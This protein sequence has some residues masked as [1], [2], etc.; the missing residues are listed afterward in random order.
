[1]EKLRAMGHVIVGQRAAHPDR[2][3]LLIRYEAE[4]PE[5]TAAYH[6]SRRAVLRTVAEVVADGVR[7]GRFRPVDPSVAA[8]GVLGMCN[9]VAWWFRPGGTQGV[10]RRSRSSWPTWRWPRC[11]APTT[12]LWRGGSGRRAQLLRD[13]L[14]HLERLL[15]R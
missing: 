1:V 6:A 2:F 14:D 12:A 11:S 5:L 8:L 15:D 9:W 4:L 13:D 10:P 3:R 7:S